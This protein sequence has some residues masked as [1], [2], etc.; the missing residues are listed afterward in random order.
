MFPEVAEF[1][2][3]NQVWTKACITPEDRSISLIQNLAHVDNFWAKLQSSTSDIYSDI[4]N[5]VNQKKDNEYAHKPYAYHDITN[6]E[7]ELKYQD[8]LKEWKVR[9]DK[10]KQEVELEYCDKWIALKNEYRIGQTQRLEKSV[11][12]ASEVPIMG[13]NKFIVGYWD[14]VINFQ[15]PH[16]KS[17]HFLLW[18]GKEHENDHY[19][20]FSRH[21]DCIDEFITKPIFIE[22]KPV[23]R[24]FGE[25]LRQLKTYQSFV[26]DA[27]GR[28]YLFTTDTKFKAAFETQGIKVIEY[29]PD[30]HSDNI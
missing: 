21:G 29:R 7:A 27:V 17:K 12:M 20:E 4:K 1:F 23:I 25:T 16:H 6:K 8:E 19:V 11:S 5:I 18:Y 13:Y 22:V 26:P 14:M 15:I 9:V 10:L 3:D 30:A 24:S 28:T 2:K